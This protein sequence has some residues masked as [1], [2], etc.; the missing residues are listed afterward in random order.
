MSGDTQV[1][2]YLTEPLAQVDPEMYELIRKEKQRQVNFFKENINF[3]FHN[4]YR[5]VVWK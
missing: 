4:Q 5:F 3:Y 1:P 2:S